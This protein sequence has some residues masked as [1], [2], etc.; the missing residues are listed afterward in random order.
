MLNLTIKQEQ[1]PNKVSD[2]KNLD[3]HTR[4]ARYGIGMIPGRLYTEYITRS[5]VN[6]SFY[7]GRQWIFDEDLDAF[8][9]DESGEVRN[10]LRFVEN[11][12]R[13][14]VRSL[15]N[16]AIRVDYTYK[17]EAVN[18]FAISRREKEFA[19]LEAQT[20]VANAIGGDV[21]ESMKAN[22]PIGESRGETE[23]MFENEYK[24]KL[25]PGINYLLKF[26]SEQNK[27]DRIQVRCAEHLAV[28]GICITREYHAHNTQLFKVIVPQ[29]FFWDRGAMEPTLHDGEYMGHVD[30]EMPVTLYEQYN[31]KD[32]QK[33]ALEYYVKQR[34]FT[35]YQWLTRFIGVIDGRV[36]VFNIEW[37]DT[38]RQTWG[39]VKQAGIEVFLRINYKGGKFTTKDCII[40]KDKEKA[41]ELNTDKTMV[42]YPTVTRYCRFVPREYVITK[43]HQD[44]VLEWGVLEYS[45][46]DY[47]NPHY[48][49]FSYKVA[50]FAYYDGEISSPID[51]AIDPQR[52]VNRIN[53]M[54]E[55]MINNSRGA[56]LIYDGDGLDAEEGEEGML[57]NIN[58]NKP[59]KLN[60]GG[61]LNNMVAKYDMTASPS[62]NILYNAA[63]AYREAIKVNSGINEAMTGTMGGKRELVGVA[64]AMIERGSLMQEDFYYA[65]GLMMEQMFQSMAQRGK[66]IYVD[67]DYLI[68]Y[69]V[70]E[71]YTGALK[72]SKEYLNEYFRIFVKRTTPESDQQQNANNIALQFFQLGLLDDEHLAEVFNRG[73][74]DDVV[75]KMREY[76][77]GLAYAKRQAADMQQQAAA[78]QD[79]VA[80]QS[81]QAALANKLQQQQMINEGQFANKYLEQ[82]QKP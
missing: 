62:I 15:K 34:K 28:D 80:A 32:D 16:N 3:Y 6:W 40:P 61:N 19:I 11:I 66:C 26:I 82:T 68:H 20:E 21:K 42:R 73:N 24:D 59:V 43:D 72:L 25:V 76:V 17:A 78:A 57:R 38:E 13:P 49:P 14:M 37:R 54:A 53:S 79:G 23:E 18:S 10:R 4:F 29:T 22:F 51:D 39:W 56:G 81:Q 63:S 55:S 31:L 77:V 44:I 48:T 12:I 35:D 7:K 75:S 36:P 8:L 5:I 1:R 2:N 64:N 70:G 65:L 45:D 52:M 74:V 69:A 41:K 60:A 71:R 46:F 9:M 58:L 33:E 27:V 67:N 30:M 47:M 50:T